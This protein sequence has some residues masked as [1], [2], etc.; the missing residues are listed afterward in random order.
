MKR[1][2]TNALK[3]NKAC[4]KLQKVTDSS[5]AAGQNRPTCSRPKYT[6]QKDRDH[7]NEDQGGNQHQ[8]KL[9][10]FSSCDS[11]GTV[12]KTLS[13]RKVMRYHLQYSC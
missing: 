11:Y 13:S 6:L 7:N 3:R 2:N 12:S 8:C 9:P 1:L 4:P 10:K 5:K